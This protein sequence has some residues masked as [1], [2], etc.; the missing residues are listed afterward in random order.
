MNSDGA[1]LHLAA[2]F[3]IDRDIFGTIALG[4]GIIGQTAESGEKYVSNGAGLSPLIHDE[5]RPSELMREHITAC[6]PMQILDEVVGVIVIFSLLQQKNG[7]EDLDHELFDLLSSHAP[8]AL[9]ASRL[10]YQSRIYDK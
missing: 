6:L 1:T 9:H 8:M 10:Y 5:L 7:L 3:G 4:E 2:S